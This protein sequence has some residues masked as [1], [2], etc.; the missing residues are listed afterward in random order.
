MKTEDLQAQGLTQ[1]Q[2]D[3]VFAEN[4]K[5]VNAIKADRDSYKTQLEAAQDALKGFEGVNVN[6]LQE[7]ITNLTTQMEADK[8]KYEQAIAD[9][10]FND[11]VKKAADKHNARDVKAVMPFLDIEKLKAS[12]NQEKDLDAAFEE[13][14]K[15]KDY[16]FTSTKTI[17]KVVSSTP[18]IKKNTDDKKSQANEAFRSLF[19]K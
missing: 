12:K 1:E 15:E 2:I 3:F 17:P 9:R 14:K 5:D 11:L 13:V 18:G 8:S 6:E 16:L 19:G 4:G 7:K 10:D